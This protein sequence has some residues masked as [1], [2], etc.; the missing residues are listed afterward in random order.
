MGITLRCLCF[1]PKLVI[2]FRKGEASAQVP[3]KIDPHELTNTPSILMN[4]HTTTINGKKFFLHKQVS[5]VV[6]QIVI[7]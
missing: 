2:L 6:D 3:T 7:E 4:S 1:S 5:S